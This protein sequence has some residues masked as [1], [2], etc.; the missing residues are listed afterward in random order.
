[1]RVIRIRV[2]TLTVSGY[3][4]SFAACKVEMRVIRIRVLTS[5]ICTFYNLKAALAFLIN[6]YYGV[7]Y[8]ADFL[9]KSLFFSNI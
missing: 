5:Q 7:F 9:Y 1:M 2:L 6:L 3:N 8:Y 4:K